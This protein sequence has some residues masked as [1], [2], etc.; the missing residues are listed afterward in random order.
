M[1]PDEGLGAA[2]AGP[3]IT[4]A[5]PPSLLSKEDMAKLQKTYDRTLSMEDDNED[6]DEDLEDEDKDK[7]NEEVPCGLQLSASGNHLVHPAVTVQ[8]HNGGT[9]G[10]TPGSSGGGGGKLN[11][12]PGSFLQVPS[13][14]HPS[15]RRHSWV[16]G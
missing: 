13:A 10:T 6:D 12:P 7:Y 14:R 1:D 3:Q 8:H 2:A 16:Y 15:R 11:W 9:G 5:P 4:I